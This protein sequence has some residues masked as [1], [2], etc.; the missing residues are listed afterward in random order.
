[1]KKDCNLKLFVFIET[2]KNLRTPARNIVQ[3]NLF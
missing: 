3:W 2:D 1:M